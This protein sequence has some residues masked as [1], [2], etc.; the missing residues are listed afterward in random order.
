MVNYMGQLNDQ[1]AEIFNKRMPLV[2][3]LATKSDSLSQLVEFLRT[4]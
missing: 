4:H 3:W 2:N 1:M